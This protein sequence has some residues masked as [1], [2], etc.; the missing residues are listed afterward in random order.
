MNSGLSAFLA[1]TALF[2]VAN[3]SMAKAI[4]SPYPQLEG[5]VMYVTADGTMLIRPEGTPERLPNEDPEKGLVRARI[6]GLDVPPA[7]LAFLTVNRDVRCSIYY[8]TENFMG[9][10]CVIT[11][12]HSHEFA[13]DDDVGRRFAGN[14]FYG[15]SSTRLNGHLS[16]FDPAEY[17]CSDA[18]RKS[19]KA[20][21]P[22]WLVNLYNKSKSEE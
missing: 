16:G 9:V 8:E 19:L 4:P 11:F 20:E 22:D 17:K 5:R 1:L 2:C 15:V 10:S 13:P 7:T 14:T 21:S 6:A 18:D 12:R 3:Q